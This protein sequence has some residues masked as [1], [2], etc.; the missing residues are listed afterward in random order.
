[1]GEVSAEEA[2]AVDAGPTVER[3]SDDDQAAAKR[4]LGRLVGDPD[5]AFAIYT[6]AIKGFGG[7]AAAPFIGALIAIGEAARGDG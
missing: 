4:A 1:M 5:R 3:A 6:E 7:V 2:T